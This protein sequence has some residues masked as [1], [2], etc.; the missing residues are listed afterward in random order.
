M[1]TVAANRQSEKRNRR[2]EED[3]EQV[4]QIL[5]GLVEKNEVDRWLNA[6][7]PMLDDDCPLDSI[8]LGKTQQVIEMLASLQEGI[9]V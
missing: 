5:S 4:K 3:L 1:P 8:K 7:N 6:P 9:Y 2:Q